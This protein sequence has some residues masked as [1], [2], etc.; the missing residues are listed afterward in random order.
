MDVW[1]YW[2]KRGD[3]GIVALLQLIQYT[4]F[5]FLFC[6][7]FGFGEVEELILDFGFLSNLPAFTN[8]SGLVGRWAV[9][10]ILNRVNRWSLTNST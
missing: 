9:L 4:S 8:W 6:L 10:L 1:Q 5:D 7:L 3:L 2:T